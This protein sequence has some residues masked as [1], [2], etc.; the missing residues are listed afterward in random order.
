MHYANGQEAKL[1]DLVYQRSDYPG[2]PEVVGVLIAAKASSEPCTATMLALATR[3][4][5]DLGPTIWTPGIAGSS[6]CTT[7]PK[8][9]PLSPAAMP[10]SPDAP[11]PDA[12]PCSDQA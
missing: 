3:Y 2:G 1:G 8:L 5:S 6:W 4:D 7:V 12:P 11:P 9:L 10:V